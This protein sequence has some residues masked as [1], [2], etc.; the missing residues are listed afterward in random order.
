MDG[1]VQRP[2]AN[3]GLLGVR[4][5]P[6]QNLAL[7]PINPNDRHFTNFLN[8][9]ALHLNWPALVASYTHEQHRRNFPPP[10]SV[11]SCVMHCP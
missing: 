5:A 3:V 2:D 1:L 4:D 8:A 6:G 11:P 7:L 10:A 9:D